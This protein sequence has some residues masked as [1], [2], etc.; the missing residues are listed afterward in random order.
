[1]KIDKLSEFERET[2]LR[3]FLH[4]MPMPQR[5]RVMAEMPVIYRKMLGLPDDL[6]FRDDVRSIV[7][8]DAQKRI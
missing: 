7:T 8:F 5:L 4:T 6:H 3:F 2:L 1:M